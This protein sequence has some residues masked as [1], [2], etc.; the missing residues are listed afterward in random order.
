MVDIM[1]AIK[2]P[3]SDMKTMGIGLIIGAIPVVNI[4]VQGYALKVAKET[5]GGNKSSIPFAVGDLVEYILNIIKSMVIGIVYMIIPLIVLGIGLVSTLT[6]LLSNANALS[7]PNV[8][9]SL[10]MTNLSAGAPILIIGG[11]LAL[12]A[13]LILPMAMMKWLKAD[14][15]KAAFGV[16]DVIKNALSVNYLIAIVVSVVYSM[17][18]VIV[19]GIV[20]GLLGLVPAVGFILVM[21]VMGLIAFTTQ[22]TT[23]SLFADTVN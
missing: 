19:L 20:A 6:A 7:D 16:V 4:L 23:M 11:L 13:A 15:I 5:I 21:L 22:V 17:I 18:L 1:N 14:S 2:K 10:L 8:T 12:I 3:F 9:A